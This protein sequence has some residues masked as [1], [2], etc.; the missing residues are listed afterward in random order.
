MSDFVATIENW[1]EK[2]KRNMDLILR[3]AVQDV[4]EE[5]TRRDPSS[6]STPGSGKVPVDDSELINSQS[7]GIGGGHSKAA[8]SATASGVKAGDVYTA[9]FTAPHAPFMEYG[10]TDENGNSINGGG[11]FFVRNAARQWVSFVDRAAA[12][13]G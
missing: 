12:K 10:T 6:P 4:T 8:F 9:V 3:Q 5:M 2:A 7:S 11:R 1:S 13:V